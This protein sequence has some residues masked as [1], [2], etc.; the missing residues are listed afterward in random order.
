MASHTSETTLLDSVSVKV[1]IESIFIK[2]MIK[3][4]YGF[5]K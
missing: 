2:F 1:E 5:K 3:K 4:M